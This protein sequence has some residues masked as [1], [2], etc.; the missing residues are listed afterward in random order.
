MVSCDKMVSLELGH[1]P[2]NK[3]SIEKERIESKEIILN[4]YDWTIAKLGH[5][6][7]V[8]HKLRSYVTSKEAVLVSTKRD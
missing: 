3:K 7:M 6:L 8:G 4:V 2:V 5:K 1:K